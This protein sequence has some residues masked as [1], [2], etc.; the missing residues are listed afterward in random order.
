MTK[1]SRRSK[2]FAVC[3]DNAGYLAS[4]NAGRLHEVVPDRKAE[5]H[6]LLRVVAESGKDYGYSAERFFILAVPL[7]LERVLVDMSQSKASTRRS[8]R[9]A[10]APREHR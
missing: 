9:E 1:R 10:R 6:G 3:I 4:L 8:D 5:A 7:A 2:T